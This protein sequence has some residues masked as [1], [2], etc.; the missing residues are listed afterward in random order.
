MKPRKDSC[1]HALLFAVPFQKLIII[2]FSFLVWGNISIPTVTGF[3]PPSAGQ[4]LLQN[5]P[6]REY[7]LDSKGYM[8]YG[9]MDSP[10]LLWP[11]LM[12]PRDASFVQ[13]PVRVVSCRVASTH[14]RHLVQTGCLGQS[15]AE[16]LGLTAVWSSN[17]GLEGERCTWMLNSG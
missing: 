7:L 14:P 5:L 13:V 2:S 4:G 3:Y 9:K 17:V 12:I 8:W 1:R 6:R 11:N 15:L 16:A 10:E